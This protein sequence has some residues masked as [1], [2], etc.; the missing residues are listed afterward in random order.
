MAELRLQRE[1]SYGACDLR[2]RLYKNYFGKACGLKNIFKTHL[3]NAI[4]VERR[5]ALTP[6]LSPRR[7][8]G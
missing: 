8:P 3:V 7:G 2:S 5:L 6:A 1:R 4:G